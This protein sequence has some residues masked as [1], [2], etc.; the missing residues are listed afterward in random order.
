[1]I[2]AAHPFTG[3]YLVNCNSTNLLTREM[4]D[5]HRNRHRHRSQNL[6]SQ[7]SQC[8]FQLQM[9]KCTYETRK[10]LRIP[11]FSVYRCRTFTRVEIAPMPSRKHRICRST[12]EFLAHGKCL[13]LISYSIPR[14]SQHAEHVL[15]TGSKIPKCNASPIYIY[16]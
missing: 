15:Y 8:R 6:L 11:N 9:S 12:Y 5:S 14:P 16:I 4:N 3:N 10:C 2:T 13:R 1:M 7:Q